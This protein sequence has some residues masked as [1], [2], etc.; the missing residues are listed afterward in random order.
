M[1]TVLPPELI[2]LCLSQLDPRDPETV[3]T[4]LSAS[5][6]SSSLRSLA[7]AHSLWKSIADEHYH[8]YRSPS[9]S[10]RT[11]F[12]ED[13]FVY[14]AARNEKDRRARSLVRD[15]QRPVN[16]LPLIDELRQRL[17]SDVIENR[18][19]APSEFTEAK[20]PETWLSLRYWAS[21]CRKT[22]L[23]DEALRTWRDIS[24]RSARD[25]EVE[26]DFER[27]LDA[28]AAFRGIDPARLA[29]ERYD[30][31]NHLPLLEATRTPPPYTAQGSSARLEWLANEVVDYMRSIGLKPSH[32][33]GFHSLDNHY[34]ELVWRRA[35]PPLGPQNEGTL[36]MT[37]VSIFCSLVR[38]LPVAK[39]LGIRA[40]MIGYPGTVLAGLSYRDGV[41]E[42]IYVNVFGEGKVLSPERLR[43]MLGA[44]GQTDSAE[45]LAPSSAREMCLR[46]ARNI[47]TSV[48]AGDRSI[49][50]PIPHE[51]SVDAL[52]S[53]S[54]ALFLFT[55]PHA[56][57][58]PGV[59]RAP[60]GGGAELLQ[61]AE[62]LES[63]VQSEY[64]LDVS[65]L[66]S[67]VRPLLPAARQ[68]RLDALCAAI[69]EEDETPKEQKLV[70]A[71]IKWPIG[72]V[73][74]HR[75]FGYLAITRGFDYRC[76]AGEQWIRQMQVDR[77]P[78][79]RH[80]PFYHVVVE[81][82]SA[83]YV[84]QEN[85]TDSFISDAEVESFFAQESLGRYFRRREWVAASPSRAGRWAFVPSESVAA[86]YPESGP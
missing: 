2:S 66:A 16:R 53:V 72:H 70:S 15:I 23:R 5:L 36:P 10:T 26:D 65:Y 69:K 30:M 9:A 12:D 71:E 11:K 86:E 67:S 14:Y 76:E 64:P 46:T 78:L 34:V 68:L 75:L 44:M 80:Q 83:R 48:R 8:Q 38:R 84:A 20:R 25:Q 73:F 42:R 43:A 74:R 60:G 33:G 39:E 57:L 40:Q 82:G 62:W 17:G 58:D 21:E 27:G 35:S 47:L 54:H 28:F 13:A 59:A 24:I 6:A 55:N 61:Y 56:L 51:L 85:I 81:D 52:Y 31:S 79:G 63:L 29:R 50:V 77:L 4:L 19:W 32:E 22:L 3:P 45:F 37:L 7:T 49:G 18:R 41:G 1:P